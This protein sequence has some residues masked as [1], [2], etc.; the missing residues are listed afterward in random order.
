MIETLILG[1]EGCLYINT[2][3][4]RPLSPWFRPYLKDRYEGPGRLVITGPV[5]TDT[6]LVTLPRLT[7]EFMKDEDGEEDLNDPA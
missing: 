6:L 7:C 3:I 2:C 4:H 5:M 1:G